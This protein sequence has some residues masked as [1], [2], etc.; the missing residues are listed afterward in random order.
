MDSR[1]ERGRG[2]SI[3]AS[4][5]GLFGLKPTRGRNSLAPGAGEAL[6]GLAVEHAVTR[7]VR[8]SA[9]L[10]DAIDKQGR[11]LEHLTTRQASLEDVFVR[12]TGRHLRE[13]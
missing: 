13:E 3:P 8:D 7:T 11:Q 2:S 10:L 4:C 9:A 5:C 12:L 1:W 6:S